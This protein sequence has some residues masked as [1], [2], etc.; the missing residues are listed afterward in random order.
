MGLATQVSGGFEVPLWGEKT[1]TNFF[2]GY[3]RPTAKLQSSGFVSLEET[4]LEI[5]PVSFFG[6][7]I[8][9]F[10][11]VRNT[12][13]DTQDCSIS[14][15]RGRLSRGYVENRAAFGYANVFS[16]NT[17]RIQTLS[18]STSAQTLKPFADE[19]SSLYGA[20]NGDT[21]FSESVALGASLPE[22][23]L[24]RSKFGLAYSRE[25]MSTQGS[26]NQQALLFL[27]K[28]YNEWAL[29]LAGGV[30]TSSSADPGLAIAGA[31]RWVGLPSIGD[32]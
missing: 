1:P 28:S 7:S 8:G 24:S 4:A 6:F 11:S 10:T 30:Y 2:Y 27:K 14:E 9:Q 21:L 17:F 20:P 26:A 32:F 15:C 29:T 13:L 31:I 3:L 22:A 25:R 16:Q 23:L 19:S 12:K 18:H 5:F